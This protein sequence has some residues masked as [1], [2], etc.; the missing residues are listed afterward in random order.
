MT[1]PFRVVWSHDAVEDW[2]RLPLADAEPG[3]RA[4]ERF[5]YEGIVI[6][7]GAA[8]YTLFV[9]EHAIVLLLAG[10]TLYVDRVRRS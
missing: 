1:V 7:T 5:P 2:Q 4:V 3:A 8:E 9:G 6:P 10:D